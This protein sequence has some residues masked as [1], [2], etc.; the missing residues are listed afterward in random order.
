[1]RT[2]FLVGKTEGKRKLIRPRHR[3]KDNI[4]KDLREM[5]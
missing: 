3:W 2:N 1:M 4:K 5:E